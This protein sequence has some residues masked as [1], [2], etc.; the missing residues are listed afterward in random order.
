MAEIIQFPKK[1]NNNPTQPIS[2]QTIQEEQAQLQQKRLDTK[3]EGYRMIVEDIVG[4]TIEKLTAANVLNHTDETTLTMEDFNHF[5]M[6]MIFIR[7]VFVAF[8]CRN[9]KIPH[10]LHKIAANV[11]EMTTE[12]LPDGDQLI[13]FK[14]KEGLFSDEKNSSAL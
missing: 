3:I 8:I 5:A 9:Q 14:V 13:N 2:E 10:T 12:D 1:N 7:E 6:D 11:F 4:E